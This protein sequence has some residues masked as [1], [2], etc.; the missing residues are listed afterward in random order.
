MK[1]DRV[2]LTAIWRQVL[3]NDDLDENSDLF[4]HGGTSLHVLQIVG[5]IYD[6]L[7]LDV[8]PRHVFL[9][10]SPQGL[11]TYLEQESCEDANNREPARP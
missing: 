6:G 4:E 11:A 2:A 7:G 1:P 8:R 5:A 3:R 10:A 9:H